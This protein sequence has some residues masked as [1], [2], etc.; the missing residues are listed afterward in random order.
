MKTMLLEKKRKAHVREVGF[1]T[2]CCVVLRCCRAREL[3]TG[4][5]WL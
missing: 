4:T 1:F 2:R 3:V 5:D